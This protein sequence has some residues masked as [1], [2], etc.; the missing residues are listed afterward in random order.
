MPKRR[1]SSRPLVSMP[2]NNQGVNQEWVHSNGKFD[3]TIGKLSSKPYQMNPWLQGKY[4]GKWCPSINGA[5]HGPDGKISRLEISICDIFEAPSSFRADK[6]KG[7]LRAQEDYTDLHHCNDSTCFFLILSRYNEGMATMS[8]HFEPTWDLN[9]P[10]TN[11]YI[12]LVLLKTQKLRHNHNVIARPQIH[13]QCWC[14]SK[15]K[16]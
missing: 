12:M 5:N 6:T 9:C 2:R 16:S 10:S 1:T 8:E 14:S 13:L 15:P 11:S 7:H 4:E 3:T